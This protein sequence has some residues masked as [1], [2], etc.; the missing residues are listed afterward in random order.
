M[1]RAAIVLLS[2][3][4]LTAFRVYGPQPSA[5]V[6]AGEPIVLDAAMRPQFTA[7]QLR[8]SAAATRAGFARWADTE[9]GRRLITHFDRREFRVLI[10]E[11]PREDG[12]GRAP[13]PGLAT[14]VAARD[15]AAV[16]EYEIILNPK[17]G[18][19]HG[20]QAMRGEPYSPADLMAAACAAEMLHIYYYSMGISLP[21]HERADFQAAWRIAIREIGYPNMRH[22][23]DDVRLA[24]PRQQ[25][26]RIIYW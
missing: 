12:A 23:G 24:Q 18:I 6:L 19:T 3:L 9:D 16:K 20:F 10:L 2:L 14:L 4:F 25:Q 26:A 22:D 21:H 13:Q 1:R 15:H 7:G 8:G 17:F 5:F 11:D